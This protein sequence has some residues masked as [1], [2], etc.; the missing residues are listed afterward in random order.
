MSEA[1]SSKAVN[2]PYCSV[3][4][5]LDGVAAYHTPINFQS[6]SALFAGA[7]R[8]DA[9][10]FTVSAHLCP[11]C[12]KPVMWLNEVSVGSL[13]QDRGIAATHLLWPKFAAR[14]LSTHVPER[15]RLAA[16][17]AAAVLQVSAKASAALSRRSLQDVLREVEGVQGPTLQA[18][19]AEVLTKNTLPRYLAQDL[20]AIR[21][22]GNFA[23][24]PIKN[25][26]TGE[27]V[28][29]EPGEAEWTLEVLEGVLEFYFAEVKQS[30][31]R[32]AALN[33]KL[34][35]AGKRP[36]S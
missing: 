8:R 31:E 6:P 10:I 11:D 27:I 9:P 35:T 4:F 3:R 32:R 15:Y 25:T 1:A 24:H 22:V 29:V 21:V 2:C 20:D 14:P 26:N 30:A 34:R 7:T 18:E 19:I 23:A 33:D 17:E 28:E 16:S 13:G 5:S 12:D 36:L